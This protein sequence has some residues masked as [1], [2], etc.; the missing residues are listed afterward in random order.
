MK[1]SYTEKKKITYYNVCYFYISNAINSLLT[2]LT[3]FL[4]NVQGL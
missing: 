4:H 3:H 1:C 2:F